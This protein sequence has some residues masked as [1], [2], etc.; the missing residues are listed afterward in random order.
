MQGQN[1]LNN[2]FFIPLVILKI[3]L[4]SVM[5][6][7]EIFSF[8]LLNSEIEIYLNVKNKIS[9]SAWVIVGKMMFD[10]EFKADLKQK[11]Q[12]LKLEGCI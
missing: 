11:Y 4:T 7:D 3:K 9:F 1:S 8:L 12:I 6:G 5:D 10:T 2:L